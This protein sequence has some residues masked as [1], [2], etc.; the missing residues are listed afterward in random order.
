[1]LMEDA[2]NIFSLSEAHSLL[3]LISTNFLPSRHAWR[4]EKSKKETA[5]LYTWLKVMD[6]K[7]V[8]VDKLKQLLLEAIKQTQ[9]ILQ[10]KTPPTTHRLNQRTL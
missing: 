6:R 7:T 2:E 3:P 9:D 8:G 1:M 10:K 5:K 4:P